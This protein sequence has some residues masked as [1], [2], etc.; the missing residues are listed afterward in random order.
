MTP[1]VSR[2]VWINAAVI[3]WSAAMYVLGICV[4]VDILTAGGTK[5]IVSATTL[6]DY[7]AEVGLKQSILEVI[8]DVHPRAVTPDTRKRKDTR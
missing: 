6:P 3:V 5:P 7:W 1:S 2:R 8:P 4:A